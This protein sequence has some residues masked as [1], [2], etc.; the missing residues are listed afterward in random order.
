[1]YRLR[2]RMSADFRVMAVVTATVGMLSMP[3]SYLLLERMKWSLMPQIQPMRAL[4]YVTAMTVILTACAAV[5]AAS[6][7][8]WWETPLWFCVA[9]LPPATT[10]TFHFLWERKFVEAPL[11]VLLAA[12]LAMAVAL[13]VAGR[14]KQG[15]VAVVA[16][17]LAL[18]F[19]VMPVSKVK[20]F[21]RRCI[22]PSWTT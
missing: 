3:L 9:F 2:S 22:T 14:W 6:E 10:T 12:A 19:V 15:S 11:A 20:Q 7:R 16:A 4:L 21:I 13:W 17:A 1:M 8:R 18:A 5:V